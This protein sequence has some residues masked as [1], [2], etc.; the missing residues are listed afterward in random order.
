MEQPEVL[1]EL[2]RIG[3]TYPRDVTDTPSAVLRELLLPLSALRK[4][5]PNHFHALRDV[6]LALTRG[7]KAGVLGA[8]R[9]GKSTLAGIVAGL[10][11]PTTGRVIARGSR[12][13]IARPGA[14]F[15]PG[16]TILEN[17]SLRAMLHGVTGEALSAIIDR[18]LGTCGMSHEQAGRAIGNLSPR[19][20]KQLATTL[21]VDL[22]AD[23]MVI[24]EVTGSGTGDARWEIRG[25]LKEKVDSH[26]AL[27]LS[28]DAAF[29]RDM[30]D[31]AW[32]LHQG[33]LY[34]PFPVE[35][36][37]EVYGELPP[38]VEVDTQHEQAFDPM[39]PP[40]L[41]AG[42]APSSM[43]IDDDEAEDRTGDEDV[44]D[45]EPRT[46][47]PSKARSPWKAPSI[48]V[49]GED[50]LHSRLSL[51]RPPGTSM[52]VSVEMICLADQDFT[53]GMFVL[54]GGNSGTEVGRFPYAHDPV[55]LNAGDRMKLAFELIVPDWGE[56][57]YG[58]T[59]CPQT[60]GKHFLHEH[61]LKILIFGV[62]RKHQ[63][64]RDR[65]LDIRN[66]SFERTLD[67]GSVDPLPK[68]Q[69]ASRQ[70]VQ[71]DRTAAQAAD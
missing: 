24:D 21:L 35:Q 48:I 56:D 32:V 10:L 27:V 44:E 59:F 51:I 50:F 28:A 30:V 66:S 54:H 25:R 9:S 15:K 64:S 40:R 1:V 63:D 41:R 67:N 60:K 12:S 18:T 16:L 70:V 22:P 38:E 61:R 37:I 29:M 31:D 39:E 55:P 7:R 5:P 58:L 53:G 65:V 71:Q 4:C 46:T 68:G 43:S 13:L 69:Q 2:E 14:G 3:R 45:F 11:Q 23:V 17:L 8:H 49:D 33:R 42:A 36:A 19:V 26:T 34:G 6:D 57:F 47:P 52:R 20:I 62:G